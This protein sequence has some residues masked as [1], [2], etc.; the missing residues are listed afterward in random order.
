MSTQHPQPVGSVA[1]VQS[2]GLATGVPFVHGEFGPELRSVGQHTA[3]A[4]GA[5]MS[6]GHPGLGLD[7]AMEGTRSRERREMINRG[8]EECILV[9]LVKMVELRRLKE[10]GQS[11]C[12]GGMKMQSVTTC[13]LLIWLGTCS[14]LA[15]FW[16]R[17]NMCMTGDTSIRG[18]CECDE[19]WRGCVRYAYGYMYGKMLIV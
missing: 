15:A 4:L 19:T 7:C 12:E 10:N 3:V 11:C 6:S 13:L 9:A 14:Y 5:P 2:K 8:L 17:R 18:W 1:V 16:Q